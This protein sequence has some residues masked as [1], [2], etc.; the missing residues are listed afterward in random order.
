MRLNHPRLLLQDLDIEV[1][2]APGIG[3]TVT[4]KSGSLVFLDQLKEEG[5]FLLLDVKCKDGVVRQGQ[6][7]I[8][9]FRTYSIPLAP[10]L[11]YLDSVGH[12]A[13]ASSNGKAIRRPMGAVAVHG[14]KGKGNA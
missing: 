2:I 9:D 4:L 14:K 1:K 11:D 10:L 8:N 3:E 5:E 13:G 6:V 7:H 12:V